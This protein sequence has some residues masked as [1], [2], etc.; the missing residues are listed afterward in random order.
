MGAV[1]LGAPEGS[2]KCR[3]QHVVCVR[4]LRGCCWLLLYCIGSNAHPIARRGEPARDPDVRP[5]TREERRILSERPDHSGA[6]DAE[7]V[8]F[9]VAQVRKS[10]TNHLKKGGTLLP[11]ELRE[12]CVKPI[13]PMRLPGLIVME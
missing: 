11:I 12:R 7:S 1:N 4:C 8:D 13:L 5:V 10:L 2:W 3:G 6:T 9:C